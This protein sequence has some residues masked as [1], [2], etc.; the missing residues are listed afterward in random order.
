MNWFKRQISILPILLKAVYETVQMFFL[1]IGIKCIEW[2]K[3]Y[4]FPYYGAVKKP[5]RGNSLDIPN[6]SPADL[7]GFYS[8]SMWSLLD[9]VL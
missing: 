3:K 4:L 7:I 1:V 2:R 5:K 9:S 8:V 6:K